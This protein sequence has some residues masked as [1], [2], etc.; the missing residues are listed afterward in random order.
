MIEYCRTLR[1][2]RLNYLGLLCLLFLYIPS[3][4]A[5]ALAKLGASPTI[6]DTTL[7]A[8]LTLFLTPYILLSLFRVQD[9][10]QHRA[11]TVLA[12]ILPII[13]LFWPGTKG[14]NRYYKGAKALPLIVKLLPLG[15]ILWFILAPFIMVGLNA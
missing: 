9:A 8:L 7:T 3:A 12:L 13:Y 2:G 14:E 15:V 1:L 10:G 6:I 4:L 11:W 5:L